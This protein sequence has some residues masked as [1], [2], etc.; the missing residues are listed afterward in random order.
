MSAPL[1]LGTHLAY[2][3]LGCCIAAAQPGEAPAASRDAP[4]E[5]DLGARITAGCFSSGSCCIASGGLGCN[6]VFCCDSVCSADSSCCSTGW[7][8]G[9]ADLA[10][11]LCGSVCAGTCPSDGSCCDSHSGGACDDFTCCDLVCT[12]TPSCCEA[13]WSSACADLARA[14]CGDTCAGTCPAPGDCCAAHDGGGCEVASCCG[15]VCN[16]LPSCCSETWSSACA[17]YANLVCAHC[18]EPPRCPTVGSCCEASG[19]QT[20]CERSTCCDLVCDN[21]S[22]CCDTEWD[23]TCVRSAFNICPNVCDC[24]LFGDFDNNG[25]VDLRDVATF[26]QCL[27]GSGGG[28]VAAGCACADYDGNDEA[29]LEDLPPLINAMTP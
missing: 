9:C 29:Y 6:D 26:M 3:M 8:Q 23:I 10:G 20:G 4:T 21:D 28:P 5:D 22:Y 25:R 18:S 14:I 17:D 7:D 27:T 19:T 11:I 13:V 24:N 1:I 16:D 2:V 12:N 15:A